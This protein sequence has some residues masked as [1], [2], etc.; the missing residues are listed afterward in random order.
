MSVTSTSP[1][2]NTIAWARR[3]GFR[4]VPLHPRSKAAISRDYVLS[5]YSPPEDSFWRQSQDLNVGL[6]LGPLS[7]GPVD[8]DLDC[9]EARILASSFLPPTPAIFGRPSAPASHYLYQVTEPELPKRALL[10]PITRSTIIEMR[11]D[12]GHQTMMP[13]S[14]HPE[15]EPISWLKTPFPDVPSISSTVLLDAIQF[16]ATATLIA[17]HVWSP[18]QRNEACKHL[19]GF[20]HRLAWP[21]DK[22]QTII[23]SVMD[24]TGDD[25]RTR[26]ATI[27]LT[28]ARA[29][30]GAK[31]TGARAL[32][33]LLAD[34]RV[35]DRLVEWSGGQESI[36][37]DEYNERFA[38]VSLDGKFRVVDTD[39]PS[40]NPPVFMPKED[41]LNIQ[42]VDYD[43]I[44]DKPVSRARRWLASPKRK[45][46]RRVDFM[47]GEDDLPTVL[48]LW[49]GW[50]EK[51]QEGSCKA[52]LTLLDEV[53]CGSD[54]S[55]FKWLLNWFANIVRE[56]R[57]KPYTAP[58]II[59]R[60]GAG[61]SLF[62]DYFGRI[63]GASY[64]V[65]TNDEHIFGRFNQH[66]GSTL[67]LHSEE[68]LY[69]GEKK[70]RGVIKSL[71]TDEFRMFESK[72]IDA[73]QVRNYLRL[74]LT[75]NEPHAAPAE[76]DDRRFTVFDLKDRKAP[77]ALVKQV[78]K[79]MKEGGPAALHYHLLHMDYDSELPRTNLS[80]EAHF[81]LKAINFDPIESWWYSRL[82]CGALV[83][84][85][86]AW[87]TRPIENRW[88]AQVGS[89]ALYASFR[90]E[91]SAKSY[92]RVPVP[93]EVLFAMKLARM[94]GKPKF[95]RAQRG[96]TNPQLD[97]IPMEA[98][99]LS[100]RQN[101]IIDMPSLEECREAFQRYI[102]NDTIEWPDV[103]DDDTP[104]F[105]KY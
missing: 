12:G 39:V 46:Y 13:G 57:H 58:V 99:Y 74:I 83:P 104:D 81:D 30:R 26:L 73:R 68:A 19:A 14:V 36:Y 8:V 95:K 51:P 60:Q 62:T 41:F 3:H 11:A 24:L 5:N 28:Y 9:K 20:F 38:V 86:L 40:S 71:I 63:L 75:S 61:K 65:V 47:P 22:T 67:L 44:D 72:G 91:Y 80:N 4:P 92:S 70:H 78:V 55:L 89:P 77:P 21:E 42:A 7:K 25:D 79:E 84:D 15:G 59:G 16:I 23:K 66:L 50:A 18:G 98:R 17:R 29:E 2:Q 82:Q 35:V 10:D 94:V 96:Y 69:G 85:F 45:A 1:I 102:G 88:P 49:T 54:P 64:T 53:I 27:R 100:D 105:V 103:Y 31:V 97:N 6:L 37:L 48:N 90:A 87:A 76:A 56:P 93:S 101:S 33:K 43:T 32:R 34:D 52:W